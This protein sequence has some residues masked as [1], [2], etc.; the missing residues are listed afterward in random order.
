LPPFEI[1]TPTSSGQNSPF[2]L[3]STAYISDK[4]FHP[5]HFSIHLNQFTH[6]ED[7]DNMFFQNAETLNHNTA[8]F[9]KNLMTYRPVSSS[10]VHTTSHQ[11]VGI[12]KRAKFNEVIFTLGK[13]YEA[14]VY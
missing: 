12:Q 10:A 3:H 5:Y 1:Y 6:P 13:Q 11:C 14:A 7:A 8:S 2:F 9:Y 4:I